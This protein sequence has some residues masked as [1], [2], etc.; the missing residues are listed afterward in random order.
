MKL[1]SVVDQLCKF[2]SH[3]E[4][5]QKIGYRRDHKEYLGITSDYFI[6]EDYKALKLGN[7][8]QSLKDI[9]LVLFVGGFVNQKKVEARNDNRTYKGTEF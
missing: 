9:A 8:F 2:L 3:E 1:T 4:T 6:G 7:L 5:R